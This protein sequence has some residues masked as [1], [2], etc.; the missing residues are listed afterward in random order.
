L[1]QKQENLAR[2][3]EQEIIKEELT[4]R[5]AGL[6]SEY[7]AP[8]TDLEERLA[9]VWQEFFGIERIGIHD[10][11]FGLGGDSLSATRLLSRLRVLFRM[12]LPPNSLFEA[13]TIA[14]LALY[15]EAIRWAAVELP[16]AGVALS[17]DRDEAEL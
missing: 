1:T 10:N 2:P 15:I 7:V 11:F 16:A 8:Q 4:P 6:E 12:D 17:A 3:A 14:E 5:C 13:P 9:T